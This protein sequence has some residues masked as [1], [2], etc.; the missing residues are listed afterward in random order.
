MIA[1]IARPLAALLLV[2]P[3]GASA[4][5]VFSDTQAQAGGYYTG[6]LRVTHGCGASPTISVQVTIPEGVITARP[7]PKPGWQLKIATARLPQ[8]IAGEGGS[9]I[10]QRVTAIT[11]TGRL[12][13]DEFDEFGL[14][15]KLPTTPGALYFPTIQRCEKGENSWTTIP[16]SPEHWHHVPSP[17]PMLILQGGEDSPDH[18]AH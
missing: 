6:Y 8:P 1:R 2:V 4:H 14:S 7:Q 18:M 13:V 3:A 11:W 10:T 9:S 5:V 16:P 12:P 15:M 17:A